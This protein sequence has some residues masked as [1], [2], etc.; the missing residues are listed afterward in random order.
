MSITLRKSCATALAL[1]CWLGF[2]A[3]TAAAEEKPLWE[4]GAGG[5]VLA[6]PDY[7]GSDQ[8]RSYVLPVPYAVY[9]GEFLKADRDGVRGIF[10]DRENIEFNLSAGASFPIDSKDNDARRG[11][12]DL[13][14]TVEF[15]PAVDLT[16]WRSVDRALKLTL[17]LPLRS[18][19]TVERSPAY[20]GWLFSPR[21]NL[22]I[23]DVGG[24]DGWTLGLVASPKYADGRFHRH[25]YSVAPEFATSSRP[26][27]EA[28]S[29]YGGTEFLAAL[30]KRFPRWWVGGFVRYD[31]LAG[32]AF[33]DSPLVRTRGY[34]AAGLAVAWVFAESPQ[35]VDAGN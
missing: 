35:R 8:S 5:T 7:R 18:G 22:D 6:F 31:A 17:R 20:I 16:L 9:R 10:F 30:W 4:L 29:G 23:D 25:F 13:K 12:P 27:Y 3:S 21:V 28:R 15:G 11:M 24:L 32:A 14:P 19:F 2:T 1:G 34:L 33:E 26:A